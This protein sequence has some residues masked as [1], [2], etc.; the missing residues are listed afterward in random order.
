ME[1]YSEWYE[2]EYSMQDQNDWY[3]SGETF[4]TEYHAHEEAAILYRK[5]WDTR[6]AKVV[7]TRTIV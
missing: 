1:E 3:R 5:G 4:G 6:V 7:T 2:V